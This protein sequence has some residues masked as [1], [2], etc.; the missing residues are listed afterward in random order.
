MAATK[1][2]PELAYDA[3]AA[4]VGEGIMAPWRSLTPPAQ[5]HWTRAVAAIIGA[6]H[7]EEETKLRMMEATNDDEA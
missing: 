6:L 5:A 7:G 4:S 3:Y 1:N 2:L